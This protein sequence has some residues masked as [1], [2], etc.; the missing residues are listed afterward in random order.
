VHPVLLSFSYSDGVFQIGTYGFLIAIGFLLAVFLT[1]RLSK[2]VG[3][4][5]N[6]VLDTAFWMTLSGIFG[7]RLL[8]F[9]TTGESIIN[10]PFGIFKVW[11]GGFV[12][13]GAFIF[14]VPVLI[15]N[16][17]RKGLGFWK[18]MD[19][20]VIGIALGHTFGRLGCFMAGCCHG[21]ATDSFLGVKFYS[22]LVDPSLRGVNVHPTQ[23]YEAFVLLLI[24]YILGWVYKRKA[25]DGQVALLYL[26]LY[27]VCRFIIEYFRGDNDRGYV[28]PDVL[29]VSQFVSI[30][31]LVAGLCFYYHRYKKVRVL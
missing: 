17:R 1:H 22:P 3:L 24:F 28:V 6:H 14:A 12:F 18:T 5:V 16:L 13:Y 4:N 20:G 23:L 9:I 19:I 2:Q 7:A 10:N 27:S 8:F 21:K 25:F 26:I 15:Y 11:E 30:L 29:S 31:V